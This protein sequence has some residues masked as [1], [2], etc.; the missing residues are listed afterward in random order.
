M[1]FYPQSV[2]RIDEQNCSNYR[3]SVVTNRAAEHACTSPRA[4]MYNPTLH[5]HN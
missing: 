5:T 2:Q 4:M 3:Y 1:T